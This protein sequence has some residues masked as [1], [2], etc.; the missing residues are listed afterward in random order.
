MSRKRTL[1]VSELIKRCINADFIVNVKTNEEI[2]IF[3]SDNIPLELQNKQVLMWYM[4]KTLTNRILVIY[5]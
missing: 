4:Q 1:Y 2:K 3:S 5:I